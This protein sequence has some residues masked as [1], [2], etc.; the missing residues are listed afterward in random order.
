MR[1]QTLAMATG[2][3]AVGEIGLYVQL[4]M[5]NETRA[6]GPKSEMCHIYAFAQSEI[7][8]FDLSACLIA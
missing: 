4:S 2:V 7:L 5:E 6:A 1:L 3:A 8:E